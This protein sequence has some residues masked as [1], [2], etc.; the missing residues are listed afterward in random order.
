MDLEIV[1]PKAAGIDVGSRS[2]FV[3]K[4]QQ[5]D[6]VRE[7]GVCASDHEELICWLKKIWNQNNC[8][9]VYRQLLA[10]SIFS[11]SGSWF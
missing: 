9:G 7:F 4:G 3:A 11:T 5:T 10:K 6:D 8:Y 1:N 2:H